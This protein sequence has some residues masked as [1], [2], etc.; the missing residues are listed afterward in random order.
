MN[1]E[2]HDNNSEDVHQ[3]TLAA[4]KLVDDVVNERSPYDLFV[5]NLRAIGI[6]SAE[7]GDYVQQVNE[8][9]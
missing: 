7:G 5:E 1:H 4:Q 9:M 8:R 3:R 6:S 2:S